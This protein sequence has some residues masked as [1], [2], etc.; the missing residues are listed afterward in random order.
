MQPEAS[1][2][3]LFEFY[4]LHGLALVQCTA[5]L[6]CTSLLWFVVSLVMA[7]C[8][9]FSYYLFLVALLP[10]FGSCIRPFKVAKNLFVQGSSPFTLPEGARVIRREA[11]DE[12]VMENAKELVED[13]HPRFR[14]ET[15]ADG[16]QPEMTSVSLSQSL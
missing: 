12:G 1:R 4:P 3:D 15:D 14:R 5:K 7:L 8:L 9:R 13:L 11:H 6:A 16:P 10:T 2:V